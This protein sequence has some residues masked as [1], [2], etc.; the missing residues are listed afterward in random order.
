MFN[1]EAII[2]SIVLD[3]KLM[4]PDN[5][6]EGYDIFIGKV[7]GP[8]DVYGEIHYGDAWEPAR[9]YVCDEEPNKM[10]IAFMVFGDK[11]HMDFHGSICHSF[12][13]ISPFKFQ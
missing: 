5:I 7:I 13:N 9:N 1:L 3:D 6:A 8:N 12:T 11:S 2:L 4:H 10:P